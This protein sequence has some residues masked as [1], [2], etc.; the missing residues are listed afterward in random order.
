MK[1]SPKKPKTSREVAEM[2]RT[3]KGVDAAVRRTV[4]KIVK[5]RS[6]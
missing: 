6:R 4:R 5:P 1:R 2:M 3:G